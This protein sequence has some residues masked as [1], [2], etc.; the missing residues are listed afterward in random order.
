[1][2]S[3]REKND[4]LRRSNSPGPHSF[5]HADSSPSADTRR[6]SYD[7]SRGGKHGNPYGSKES[8]RKRGF[9]TG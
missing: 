5:V 2:A 1:M 4:K 3:Y 8:Q 9:I 7:E 6:G